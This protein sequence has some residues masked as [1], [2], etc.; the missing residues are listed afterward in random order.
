MLVQILYKEQLYI[1]FEVLTPVVMY[2][3]IFWDITQCGPLKGDRR[4][5]GT[6]RLHIQLYNL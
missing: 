4:F 3:P 5:G 2:G 1:G 6:Y